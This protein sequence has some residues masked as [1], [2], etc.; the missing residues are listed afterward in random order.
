MGVFHSFT[1]RFVNNRFKAGEAKFL[2]NTDNLN[3]VVKDLDS[4]QQQYDSLIS[5]QSNAAAAVTSGGVFEETYVA[6]QVLGGNRLVYYDSG[7]VYYYDQ[8]DTSL[9]GKL[10]GFTKASANTDE[11][12]IVVKAGK[13]NNPGWGLIQNTVYYAGSN[14]LILSTPPTTN[15]DIP[16]G[17]ALDSD[18]LDINIF[19]Q[20]LLN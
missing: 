10:V 2:I 3:N 11:Q 12:V 4:L 1:R 15:M 18:N 9:W 5:Q 19:E 13:M 20:V 17:L 16:V 14:G 6:G 8:L 7:K